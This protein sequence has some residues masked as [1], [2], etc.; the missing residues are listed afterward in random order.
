M[1]STEFK[2]SNRSKDQG[3][4]GMNMNITT[5][6]EMAGNIMFQLAKYPRTQGEKSDSE[7]GSENN[8]RNGSS[9]RARV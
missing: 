8:L 7:S 5:C 6:Q 4:G 1:V 3:R 9:S 2:I